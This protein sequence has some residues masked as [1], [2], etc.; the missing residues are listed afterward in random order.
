[1]ETI[2]EFF[3]WYFGQFPA[4]KLLPANGLEFFP[5]FNTPGGE[6]KQ[7]MDFFHGRPSPEGI[8]DL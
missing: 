2:I 7:L 6:W 4:L 1:L 8:W 5:K 3:P